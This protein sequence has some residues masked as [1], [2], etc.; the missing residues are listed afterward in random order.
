MLY[1]FGLFIIMSLILNVSY[2]FISLFFVFDFIFVVIM[3][4]MCIVGV[5]YFENK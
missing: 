1:Y 5:V 3:I 4:C 2:L